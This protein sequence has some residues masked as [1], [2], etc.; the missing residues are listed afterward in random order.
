MDDGGNDSSQE[1]ADDLWSV[2]WGV[3]IESANHMAATRSIEICWDDPGDPLKSDP[4]SCVNDEGRSGDPPP[5]GVW[6]FY[7]RKIPTKEDPQWTRAAG[8]QRGLQPRGAPTRSREVEEQ[9]RN[10]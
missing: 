1:Q 4:S 10:G 9:R 3:Y 7:K 6:G 2:R 5:K 8:G